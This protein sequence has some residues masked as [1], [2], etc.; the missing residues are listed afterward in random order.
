[1]ARFLILF[2]LLFPVTAMAQ[3]VDD[4]VLLD[5]KGQSHQLY[6]YS[7]AGAIV[8]MIQGN[9]CPIF[10]NMVPDFKKV[11][12]TFETDDVVFL[13]MNSN[14]Q[15]NRA[16]INKEAADWD[17]QT[18]ILVDDSQL[19]G[20][21]LGVTRTAEVF[22]INPETW[23][24][25]YRGPLNDRL[26]YER[27][28]EFS[29]VEY[30]ADAVSSLLAGKQVETNSNAAVGCLINFP[31]VNQAQSEISYSKTIAP[32]LQENCQACHQ[33]GGIAPWSMSSYSMI[34]G[35]APMIREV[36]R[37]HRMPPWHADPEIGQ[38]QHD[39]SLSMQDRQDLIHWIEA[40]APRGKGEDP[41]LTL[42]AVRK[43]FPLGEPDYIID[44]PA[45][46]VPAS[47]IVDYQFPV[48]ASQLDRDVWLRAITI[49]P[50]DTSVVHHVL[51]GTSPP[52]S[53]PDNGSDSLFE[54]YLGG[55]A[56]GKE[57][58][59]MPEGTG[60][61][62]PRGSYFLLQMHYTPVGKPVTDH[63]RVA[64][65]FHKE[66]PEN[67][68]RHDVVLNPTIQIPA[69]SKSHEEGAYF[70]FYKDAILYSV[71]PHSHYRGKSSTFAL[72]YP[73]GNEVTLLS[74][75]NYD[76][77]WQRGYD[78]VE[79]LLVPAGSRLI[80][81]TVYDN[82]AQNPG[83]PDPSRDIGWGLQSFDEMLYGDF[84]YRWVEETSEN[85]FHD[86]RRMQITQWFGF[87]DSNMDGLLVMD[88]I[89]SRQKKRMKDV[90][91]NGD[92]NQDSAISLTEY[93]KLRSR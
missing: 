93:L 89:P 64:L 9:G 65:Y 7:D 36:V 25:V 90:F 74:V 42:V 82:S 54:N 38:W 76:F 68:L 56:P 81:K 78:F 15:D 21:S 46:A 30:V 12:R 39:R 28:R 85:P 77:N 31:H 24:I 27:Q 84:V 14:L 75:P 18:P 45:F 91:K 3:R 63:T 44:I 10:R 33:D 5:H 59:I 35:F 13:M 1:M 79:P 41:L 86:N 19:I 11:K 2:S 29:E 48:V 23:E 26:Q 72:R 4:F 57:S 6:Y 61:F 67:I 51:A 50:G 34:Q 73:E 32:L 87:T 43:E 69:Y 22:V 17:I 55:Y 92:E 47:G 83:N 37:T 20:E 49:V 58:T 88:E 16:S 62:I 66:R 8:L 60:V 80:H 71:L 70:E 53:E 40:G 52:G